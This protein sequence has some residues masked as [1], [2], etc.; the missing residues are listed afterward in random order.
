MV[1]G[2]EVPTWPRLEVSVWWVILVRAI[3]PVVHESRT[4]PS[5]NTYKCTH[6]YSPWD[7]YVYESREIVRPCVH[8]SAGGGGSGL[9]RF[10]PHW[11]ECIAGI[12]PS[13]GVLS[14]RGTMAEI[15]RR[16]FR[17]DNIGTR[18]R[19]TADSSQTRS[20]VYCHCQ[21]STAARF[22]V[23]LPSIRL[24]SRRQHGTKWAIWL[25]CCW[26]NRPRTIF[27]SA[28]HFVICFAITNSAEDWEF[29]IAPMY[30]Y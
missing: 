17:C 26:K 7:L 9:A 5:D 22:F 23:S 8:G 19:T 24:L 30:M 25:T 28:L 20:E 13:R 3:R 14:F 29:E 10:P 27:S 12:C 4:Y 6:L 1:V 16:M 21:P 2:L 11:T 15:Q 18:F